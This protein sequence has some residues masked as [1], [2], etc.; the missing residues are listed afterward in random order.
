MARNVRIASCSVHYTP[1]VSAQPDALRAVEQAGKSGA[2]IVCIPEFAAAPVRTEQFASEPIP[3]PALESFAALAS[4]YKMYV[5]VP[6]LEDVGKP[7]HY[8]TA[9]LLDRS[10]NIAGKYRKTH[11]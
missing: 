1:G 2:D 5:I 9:V 8:N 6:M 11:L 4:R 10:G 7:R 3:G